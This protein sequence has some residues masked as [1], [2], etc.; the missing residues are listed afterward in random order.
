MPGSEIFAPFIGMIV[1]TFI[2]WTYM[3]HRRIGYIRSQRI[4][5]EKLKTREDAAELLR[6]EVSYASNNLKNLFEL[7]VL[8][9]ALCLFLFVTD[10]VDG[11]YVI[12]A[13]AFFVLRV[14]H[15]V[16]HCTINRVMLRFY[17]YAASALTLWAMLGR[18]VLEMLRG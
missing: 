1:L 3:Y 8:F 11:V 15:S 10:S 4:H 12:M 7:P 13:W 14:V 18:V 5:P 6:G 17:V 9:Y 2:V 16:I